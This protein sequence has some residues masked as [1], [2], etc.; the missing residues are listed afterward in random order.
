MTHTDLPED[1]L[2][3]QWPGASHTQEHSWDCATSN[4]QR[5]W[6]GAS[7]PRQSPRDCVAAAFQ[8]LPEPQHTW[9]TSTHIWLQAFPL[10]SLFQHQQMWFFSRVCWDICLWGSCTAS[11]KCPPNRGTASPCVAQGL[12]SLLLGICPSHQ[13]TARY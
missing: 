1:G 6:L 7:C 9:R 2:T 10:T 3:E 11:F 12:C 13:S 5:K 8:G 4:A